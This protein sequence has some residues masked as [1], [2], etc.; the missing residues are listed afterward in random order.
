MFNILN[1]YLFKKF[2]SSFILTFLILATIIFVGDFVEQ[3][4][5]STGK[6]VP[7]IIIFQLTSF[8]FPSLISFTLPVS[9]F[10]GSLMCF[11]S[12]VR[13]S[14]TIT[15]HTSGLSI[16]RLAIPGLFFYF[17]IGMVYVTSVNPLISVFEKKYSELEFMYIDRVDKF[18]SITKNGLWL[19]QDNSEKGFSSVLYAKNIK[20]KGQD[21][22]DFMVLEY[23]E[24]GFFQGRLDGS[25]AKLNN[26]YWEMFNTQV[27]PKY[28]ESYYSEYL[29]YK[30]N[31]NLDDIGDSLSSPSSIS[32]WRLVTFIN[33]LEELGYSALDF[34]MHLYNLVFMPLFI[35]ALVYLASSL[36]NGLKQSDK[37]GFTIISSLILIFFLYFLSNLL[38]ALGATSQIHPILAKSLMPIITMFIAIIIF[39]IENLR[40]KKII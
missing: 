36:V 15:M 20:N 18:A 29:L 37:F 16:Q 7:L 6:D 9:A 23:D 27:T 38:D 31:I 22:I 14:E 28:N 25:K 32:I 40:I 1:K 21:L 19:K 3:F 12:L 5:K 17:I 4:R 13:N 35:L 33:F 30:T 24:N 2:L 11:L 34:K 8:N 10:F 39:Q 26:G